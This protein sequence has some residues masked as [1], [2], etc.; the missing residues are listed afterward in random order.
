MDV[1]KQGSRDV[2]RVRESRRVLSHPPKSDIQRLVSKPR[3]K[4]K[5]GYHNGM[6]VCTIKSKIVCLISRAILLDFS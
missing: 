3:L 4:P 6:L 1:Q 5:H 2:F